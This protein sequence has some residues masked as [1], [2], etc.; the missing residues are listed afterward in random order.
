MR[1]TT[2]EK[3]WFCANVTDNASPICSLYFRTIFSPEKLESKLTVYLMHN[4][5]TRG[6]ECNPKKYQYYI[7]F[8]KLSLNQNKTS[9]SFNKLCYFTFYVA[10]IYIDHLKNKGIFIC[11]DKLSTIPN[12]F[13]WGCTTVFIISILNNFGGLPVANPQDLFSLLGRKNKFNKFKL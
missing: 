9:V 13:I 5:I 7:L 1:T 3:I 8:Y 6:D 10:Q 12:L 4:D 11:S 2:S